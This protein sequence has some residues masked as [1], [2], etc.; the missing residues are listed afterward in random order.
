MWSQQE[1]N[2]NLSSDKPLIYGK[3]SHFDMVVT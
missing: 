1:I 3:D 2:N